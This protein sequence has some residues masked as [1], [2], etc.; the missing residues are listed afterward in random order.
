MRKVL[1]VLA[2]LGAAGSAAAAQ[3]AAEKQER[4]RQLVEFNEVPI[5]GVVVGP[6]HTLVFGRPKPKFMPMIPVRTS[7]L[8]ELARSADAL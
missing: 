3:P 1:V 7:F 6:E 8:P 2:V 5:D 4:P